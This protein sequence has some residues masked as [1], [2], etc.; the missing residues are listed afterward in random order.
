MLA[1]TCVFLS[2]AV[3]TFATFQV[4]SPVPSKGWTTAGPNILSWTHNSTDRLNFTAV[5]TNADA[6]VMST[7]NQILAALVDTSLETMTASPPSGGWPTGKGFRVNLVQ[8]P[9]SLG[10][11]LAQSGEFSILP[12]N[13]SASASQTAATSQVV[14]NTQTQA[15]GSTSTNLPM[16]SP[17]SASPLSV[18]A[19]LLAAV[20]LFAAALA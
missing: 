10:T 15:G 4:T 19:G 12:P 5:L 3:S 16:A 8:D 20:A 17:N 9:Q 11:V 14:A 18:H 1:F 13:I 6:S 2:L 7:N